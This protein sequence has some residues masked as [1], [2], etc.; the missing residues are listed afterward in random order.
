MGDPVD[1]GYGTITLRLLAEIRAF[2][3]PASRSGGLPL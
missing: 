2:A 1:Y 3:R